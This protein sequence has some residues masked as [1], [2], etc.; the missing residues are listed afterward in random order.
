MAFWTFS[1][2]CP[3]GHLTVQD[4]FERETLW[5]CLREKLPIRLYCIHCDTRWDATEMQR[6]TIEF[7]LPN[8]L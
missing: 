2:T 1:A 8:A 5:I 4:G 6:D 3:N 7:A